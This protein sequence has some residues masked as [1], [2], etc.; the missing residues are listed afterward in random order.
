MREGTE[1]P[2]A[3]MKE[4][5]FVGCPLAVNRELFHAGTNLPRTKLESRV[6]GLC[7][8]FACQVCSDVHL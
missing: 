1:L 4:V 3:P 2:L 7:L 8:M 5:T 6:T